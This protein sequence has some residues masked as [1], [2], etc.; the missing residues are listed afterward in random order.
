M[1][2]KNEIEFDAAQQTA[3]D[4]C[5]DVSRRIVPITGE[6]GTGKTTILKTVYDALTAK[7]WSV[8]L[9][10]PTGKAAKRIHEA[11]GIVAVTIHRL[12]EYPFPG[13]LDPNTGRALVTTDPKR[14]RRNP[15]PYRVVLADEYAMVNQEVDRNLLDALPNGG[16]IRMFGDANQLQP[17]ESSKKLQ[18]MPSRFKQ[19]LEKFNG[20]RLTNIHRQ[21]E[22]SLIITNGHKIV[23]GVM[24]KA[25]ENYSIK[26]TD[27][28]VNDVLDAVYDGDYASLDN[29]IITPVKVGWVGTRKLNA[30]VQKL[31]VD[32]EQDFYTIERHPWDQDAEAGVTHLTLYKGDK[33][34]CTR[35]QYPLGIFNG[36]TGIVQS[37]NEIG[38]LV[39]D[40]GDKIVEV[41]PSMEVETRRGMTYVN[42]QKDID[43]AY[44]ITTHKAQGSEFNEVLYVM[45]KSRSWLCN[46]ANFY[47]AQ[48]RARRKVSI[49][50]DQ[51][52]LQ[53]S[54]FRKG[55]K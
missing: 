3:V 1:E 50:T 48:S 36:E 6:A 52:S 51:K 17:I 13:E 40:F 35:N 23:N 26:F 47:T 7:G 5:L 4:A 39:I 11:T 49:I 19:H 29:Q 12:L 41:P 43:L 2:L 14:D 24:P 34:I 28:P 38:C 22:G 9:C 53:L 45:N 18:Q 42:P 10:A 37:I 31:I 16:I 21:D 44:V 25:G 15:V 8:V 32:P 27:S 55:D 33:V 30:A 54:L 20:V 46:R